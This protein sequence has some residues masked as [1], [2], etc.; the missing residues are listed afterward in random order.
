MEKQREQHLYNGLDFTVMYGV[1]EWLGEE[2]KFVVQNC[3]VL[4]KTRRGTWH[5]QLKVSLELPSD[6]Q[7]LDYLCAEC[8]AHYVK[9]NG[10]EPVA[11]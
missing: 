9:S 2:T 3:D 8:L 7:H 5:S 1:K 10:N 11:A 4:V 6:P